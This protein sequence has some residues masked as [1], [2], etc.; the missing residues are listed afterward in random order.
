MPSNRAPRL[1]H[2]LVLVALTCAVSCGGGSAGGGGAGTSL[3]VTLSA[4]RTS[5]VVPL[6]VVFTSDDPLTHEYT[7][8]F[9]E[10]DPEDGPVAS[11]VYD[12]PGTYTV[13]LAER[14]P[15]TGRTGARTLTIT[16]LPFTGTTYYVDAAA[17]DD[18]NP[19]TSPASAWRTAGRIQT[20][21]MG[22]AP[23]QR[24]NLRYRLRR[25]QRFTLPASGSWLDLRDV[26]G[27][28]RFGAWATA[29]GADDPGQP[30]PVIADHP[31]RLHEST[32]ARG[33]MV[34]S[35]A[36]VRDLAFE[37]LTLS[38]NFE[39]QPPPGDAVG[40]F[41]Y[42]TDAF[43]LLGAHDVLLRDVEVT[44]LGFALLY[45]DRGTNLFLHG[46][47]IHH[48]QGITILGNVDGYSV[49]DSTV[50]YAS[51]GHLHYMGVEDGVIRNNRW[52]GSGIDERIE[53]GNVVSWYQCTLRLSAD[54]GVD[55]VYVADN[56]FSE[57]TG[58]DLCIGQNFVRH[59]GDGHAVAAARN[60]LVERNVLDGT[61]TQGTRRWEEAPILTVA[62]GVNVLVRN[63]AFL[64]ARGPVEIG[65][66]STEFPG[67]AGV[68]L[69]NNLF[70][71]DPADDPVPLLR[72]RGPNAVRRDVRFRNNLVL[73]A[74]G[75]L[76]DHVG[77]GSFTAGLTFRNNLYERADLVVWGPSRD[78]TFPQWQAAGWDAA[79]LAGERACVAS[80][81]PGAAGFLAPC[82]TSPAIDAGTAVPIHADWYGAPRPAG[83]AI[84]IGPVERQDA[85]RTR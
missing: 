5:G 9:G 16:A 2:L 56:T 70:H 22:L 74:Y 78:F 67:T 30:R 48:N 54:D 8:R 41:T 45:Q 69:Y 62:P 60:V 1:L 6:A 24:R 12:T 76:L 33:A 43:D 10:G 58:S 50:S 53:N 39:W 57:A 40:R 46:C 17:G 32:S 49:K 44:G 18:A 71:A 75:V 19:G 35:L 64:H 34:H 68:D 28:I 37:H 51:E 72:L 61:Y 14:D 15:A 20:H 66:G 80:L 38:G 85:G 36:T 73:G 26:E 29:A 7:W 31:A 63:N 81:V 23:A 27:P 4:S 47:A 3:A 84:D 83:T 13:E 52:I 65:H 55:R 11:H 21:L 77:T 79:S 59:P 25:G 42:P 82:A